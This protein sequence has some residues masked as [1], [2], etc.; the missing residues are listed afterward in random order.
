MSPFGTSAFAVQTMRSC[1]KHPCRLRTDKRRCDSRDADS[2]ED[3]KDSG[4][5]HDGERTLARKVLLLSVYKCAGRT[6]HERILHATR[7]AACQNAEQCDQIDRIPLVLTRQPGPGNTVTFPVDASE[8][9]FRVST[10][11][12]RRSGKQWKQPLSRH[13]HGCGA[14]CAQN[15][16]A[17]RREAHRHSIR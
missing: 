5:L 15:H 7:R 11:T 14:A 4:E 1:S 12:S 6:L 9:Y 13:P 2:G 10:L 3:N 16:G 8:E 17:E